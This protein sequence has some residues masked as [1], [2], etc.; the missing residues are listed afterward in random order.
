MQKINGVLFRTCLRDRRPT[1]FGKYFKTAEQIKI[2][3]FSFL[4]RNKYQ[5]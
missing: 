4:S 2:I 3:G 1:I 5:I